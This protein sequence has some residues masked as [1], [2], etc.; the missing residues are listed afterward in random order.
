MKHLYK[1]LYA[2]V[3][4]T[5]LA[6][7][8]IARE[9]ND[10]M[11]AKYLYTH[12]AFNEAIPYYEKVAPNMN[13]PE[14]YSRLGDCYRFVKKPQQALEYYAK[15]VNIQGC[16]AETKLH[17]AQTLMNMQKYEDAIGWLKQYQAEH[18]QEQRVANLIR[19]CE[20]A[21][22]MYA[23]MPAGGTTFMPFNTDGNEFGPSI[24][25]GK[26]LITSDTIIGGRKKTDKWTGNPFFNVYAIQCDN[27]GNCG[28]D[29]KKV[30]ANLNT[31]FHDGPCSFTSDG[32]TA[33]FTRTNFSHTFFVD[34]AHK[35]PQ[36]VVH[37]EIMEATG[38]DNAAN[39]FD[40]IKPFKFNS[41]NYST[42]HPTVS[43]SGNT[44]VFASDMP[45]S[46]G[47]TDLYIIRKDAGG[48]WS[49]PVN[50][51]KSINTEGQEMFPYLHDDKTLFFAS[52]GLVG[53][54]G[55]DIYK[56]EW[57]ESANAF[58]EPVNMGIPVNS[59]FDDMSLVMNEDGGSGYFA[60][61]RTAAKTGDNIYGFTMQEVYMSLM[62]VDEF[63]ENPVPGVSVAIESVNDKRNFTTNGMGS[64]V[65]RTYPSAQYVAKLSKYGY[66]SQSVDFSTFTSLKRDTINRFIKLK[67]NKAITYNAVI[68]DAA[69]KQPIDEALVIMTKI[70]GNKKPDS[71]YVTGGQPFN[72]SMETE[73]EYQ[74]Y[75]IKPNYYSDEK[76]ITTKGMRPGSKEVIRDTI[77][78]H[79]LKKDVVI[80]IENIY[81][82][83][84]KAN[85]RE[86]AKPSLDRLL[87]VL[88]QNP[89]MQIQLNS[90]TD[91]RGSDAYNMKLSA[92]RAASVVKYLISRGIDGS[93]LKS[94]G[95][96]ETDP[97][98]KCA[99]CKKCTEE[100]HQRNRRTEFKILEI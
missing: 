88:N 85:I 50:L 49:Q 52:D 47:G 97:V 94:H 38:Y 45:G 24:S 35:D 34:K 19:S 4:A 76:H 36:G 51:G 60:S 75:A 48:K 11:K 55:L 86:D 23:A 90:H 96:G 14:V 3:A 87:D 58:T 56:A 54:G 7:P 25:K 43:P 69:T 2:A 28:N 12:L 65:T 78:L 68:A 70:G 63:S 41:K 64:V 81:Y 16:P 22:A 1:G 37:L 80:K 39:K 89:T 83:Y 73:A 26:L 42:A 8:A 100:Q 30:G 95:Y 74:V 13:D 59:S 61:N 18:P 53:L 44:M 82:D 79:E 62:V 71:M 33:Y 99:D 77:F 67:P 17:F 92:A 66:E 91:C 57:S 21:R 93:R 31:K 6:G 40:K 10:L 27:T 46:A 15:A 20:K 72:S 9:D 29:Y 32:K 84:N 5:C 98:D